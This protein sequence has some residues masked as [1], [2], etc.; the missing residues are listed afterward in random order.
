MSQ[1]TWKVRH[2]TTLP[3]NDLCAGHALIQQT[4]GAPLPFRWAVTLNS[5]GQLF[6]DYLQ[7]LM[8]RYRH[9]LLDQ[10]QT[11]L[12]EIGRADHLL[13]LYVTPQDDYETVECVWTFS[14]NRTAVL[15]RLGL[16]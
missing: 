8:R 12:A 16:E 5:I 4:L 1:Q 6:Q 13:N 14:D 10:A 7:E 9:T 11:R 3:E 15:F 2:I